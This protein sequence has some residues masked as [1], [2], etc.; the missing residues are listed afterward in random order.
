[1]PWED[2][3]LQQTITV[4][5]Y[6]YLSVY[7]SSS[8]LVRKRFSSRTSAVEGLQAP[9]N[10]K[11]VCLSIYIYT[12]ETEVFFLDLLIDCR[13]QQTKS[14]SI[15]LSSHIPVRQRFSSRISGR[16]AGSNKLDSL[17][18]Y[19]LL[20]SSSSKEKHV[21]SELCRGLKSSPPPPLSNPPTR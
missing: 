4:S 18:L 11:S 10:L 12:C 19:K 1:M 8:I 14:L 7:L 17:Q 16:I 15:Y 20:F 6:I 2:C 21:Q 9:T 13:H 5:I 3:R